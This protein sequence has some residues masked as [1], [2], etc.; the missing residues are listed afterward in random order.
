MLQP[1]TKFNIYDTVISSTVL[2]RDGVEYTIYIDSGF[3]TISND[4][5]F[6]LNT[7]LSTQETHEFQME[8]TNISMGGRNYMF[9]MYVFYVCKDYVQVRKTTYAPKDILFNV[10]MGRILIGEQYHTFTIVDNQ[11]IVGPVNQRMVERKVYMPFAETKAK[12]TIIHIDPLLIERETAIR[13]DRDALV[14]RIDCAG[15]IS[16]RPRRVHG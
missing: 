10:S 9:D 7:E 14:G 13:V 2:R 4:S 3:I 5:F 1:G 15:D 8:E 16:S 6:D 11:F 12:P